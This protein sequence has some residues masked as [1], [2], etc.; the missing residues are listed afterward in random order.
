MNNF[1]NKSEDLCISC[2][3]CCQGVFHSYAYIYNKKDIQ[4]V[5]D[6]NAEISYLDDDNLNAFPLPCLAFDKICTVYLSRPS[7]CYEHKCD[8]L[9]NYENKKIS[10]E[11]S[12]NMINKMQDV[13]KLLLP[14]LKN[15]T[16]NFD[17]NNP[18]FLRKSIIESFPDKVMSEAF[19]IK[20]R[21]M[22]MNYS[23]FLFLKETQFYIP[24]NNV[25]KR[26]Y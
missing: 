26:K 11:K 4:F 10:F 7:V 17:S 14:E 5:K 25:V 15:V 6:I 9:K 21:K 16:N 13:L 2:G 3:L 1:S 8:L 22:L 19:K 23:L 20:H 24:V 18:E 12:M